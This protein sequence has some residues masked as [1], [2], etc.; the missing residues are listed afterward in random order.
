[1]D[2]I[3]QHWLRA[4]DARLVS[5]HTHEIAA[6]L[7]ARMHDHPRAAAEY[8]RARAERRG[9]AAGLAEHPEWVRRMG[10]RGSARDTE[11]LD[12]PVPA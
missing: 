9:Y 7:S 1:M 4:L 3:Q 12:A 11:A 10:A 8:E 5:A 6:V 2:P